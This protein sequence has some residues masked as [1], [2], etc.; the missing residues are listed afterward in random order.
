MGSLCGTAPGAGPMSRRVFRYV[1]PVDDQPHAFYLVSN[2]RVLH[3]AAQAFTAET[4]SSD[5]NHAVE[6]WV[7]DYGGDLLTIRRTFQVFGTGQPL[8]DGAQW[9]GTCD[10]LPS[11]LVWHLYEVKP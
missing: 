10:R 7:E 2:V 9:R 1:V 5:S 8:P 11:G 6:F 3:V 4:V